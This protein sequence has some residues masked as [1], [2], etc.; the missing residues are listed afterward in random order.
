MKRRRQGVTPWAEWPHKRWSDRAMPMGACI[1]CHGIAYTY[2][3]GAV[4]HPCCPD[5]RQEGSQ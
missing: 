5:P 4:L 3:R 2:W 1:A